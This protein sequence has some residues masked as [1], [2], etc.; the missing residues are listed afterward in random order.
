MRIPAASQMLRVSVAIVMTGAIGTGLAL[1][2][3]PLNSTGADPEPII[4][5]ATGQWP[6]APD[7][8]QNA[9]SDA[10]SRLELFSAAE[11][12]RP[13]GNRQPNTPR[14]GNGEEM[15]IR[16]TTWTIESSAKLAVSE[17]IDEILMW[18]R[19]FKDAFRPAYDELAAAGV[20]DA[21]GG[22]TTYLGLNANSALDDPSAAGYGTLAESELWENSPHYRQRNA[23]QVE[24]DRMLSS[25]M[26]EEFIDSV[27][28]W[29]F[30]LA[31]LYVLWRLAG[32]SLDYSRW[33]AR[34]AIR[35]ASRNKRSQRRAK[36][37]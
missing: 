4:S 19:E 23:A 2:A 15:A 36:N 21:V 11:P 28:P 5:L 37:R 20:I 7:H 16:A 27:K 26:I 34:R 31:G 13:V 6:P 29:L 25:I 17:R 3:E 24:K 9:V 12:E 10:A 18:E 14:A 32:L 30:S 35:R 8:Q 33:K 22:L 1:N